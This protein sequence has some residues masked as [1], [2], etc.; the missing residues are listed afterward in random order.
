MKNPP[1]L[2]IRV[3][4]KQTHTVNQETNPCMELVLLYQKWKRGLLK[5]LPKDRD[6]EVVPCSDVWSFDIVAEQDQGNKQVV[7][8]GFVNGEEDH[9]H[10][11]L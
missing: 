8:V 2:R 3:L 11:L 1:S 7:D 9:R 5:A 4:E 10:I 6:A